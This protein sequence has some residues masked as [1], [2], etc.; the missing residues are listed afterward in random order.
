MPTEW[1]NIDNKHGEEK[2]KKKKKTVAMQHTQTHISG[3]RKSTGM[4]AAQ[5]HLI[6]NFFRNIFQLIIH[7]D[8]APSLLSHAIDTHAAIAD[9]NEPAHIPHR[10]ASHRIEKIHL[11]IIF[12]VLARILFCTYAYLKLKIIFVFFFTSRLAIFMVLSSSIFELNGAVLW[13][14]CDGCWCASPG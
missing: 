14:R 5:I 8:G 2:E 9:T 7:V 10:L 12:S 13:N 11:I 4:I 6:K 3:R 1:I